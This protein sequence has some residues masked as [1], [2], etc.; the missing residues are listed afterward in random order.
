L[1]LFFPAILILF[2]SASFA[3]AYQIQDLPNT[4]IEE[5]IILGPTKIELFLFPGEKAVKEL[6]ITNRTGRTLKFKTEIEDFIGSKDPNQLIV[7]L[8]N[9]KSSYSL[10]EL[11]KPEIPEFIL[12]HGQRI[13]LPVEISVPENAEPGGRYGVVF[14][15]VLP[16]EQ[17]GQ[18][19]KE[20]AK[21][22]IS[23]VSRSGTLFFVKIKGNVSESG[24]LKSFE[25]SKKWQ[26]KGPIKF[27]ML[28][29]NNGN[30][31]LF[32]EGKIEIFNILGKKVD[33]LSIDSYFVMPDS[34]RLKDLS[35]NK[36]LLFGKYKALISLNRG[37]KDIIDQK[38]TEFW[39]IPWKF[40][41]IGTILFSLII[42][43]LRM[44]STKFE[45]RKKT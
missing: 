28:F 32:P 2:F 34:L 3:S 38:E 36:G 29:E 20:L 35:W 45:I 6:I 25:T 14:A 12:E 30:V 27:Q 5:D 42:F 37:Y 40:V 17:A 1:A 26:E 41:L 11:L 23:V 21:S 22:Q 33:E 16:P 39:V 44:L 31:H 19:E 13:Y 43:L 24:Y 9:E 4:K 18:E 10:K 8:G 15:A 7:L